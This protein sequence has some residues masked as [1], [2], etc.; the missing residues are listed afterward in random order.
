MTKAILFDFWGTLVEN[1]VWSPIKQVRQILNIHAPFSAY[2]ERMEK[3]MMSSS[4]ESLRDAFVA[5]GK[6]FDITCSEDQLDELVGMWN[7]SWMLARPYPE[8]KA[9]LEELK[10]KYTLVLVSNTDCFSLRKVLAKFDLEGYFDF[11]FLSCEVGRIKT[12]PAFLEEV[13][14]KVGVQVEDCVLVRD[15]LQ[16][17]MKAAER[18]GMSHVLVDR[19]DRREFVSKV[20]SLRELAQKVE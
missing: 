17:D 15:S 18:V 12:D 7:K 14:A 10:E 4:F 1:G 6:E 11:V 5:V 16:S 9:V 8:T 19:K 20:R 3:A 13:M 2:V